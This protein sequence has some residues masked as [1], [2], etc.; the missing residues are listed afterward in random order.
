[1]NRKLIVSILAILLVFAMIFSLLISVIPMSRAEGLSA[2]R[3][4]AACST[5]LY[6]P[7]L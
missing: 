1:M 5:Q 3:Q 2:S 6:A 4:T 7:D